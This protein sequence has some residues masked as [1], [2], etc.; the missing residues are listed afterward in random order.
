[1]HRDD[2]NITINSTLNGLRLVS[3]PQA[4]SRVS[5]RSE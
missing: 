4:P 2:V 1:M 5:G 3:Q